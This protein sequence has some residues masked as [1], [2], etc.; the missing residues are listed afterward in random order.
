E[1]N[2]TYTNGFPGTLNN[3]YN[4]AA[5]CVSGCA[6]GSIQVYKANL[7]VTISQIASAEMHFRLSQFANIPS[8]S[9]VDNERSTLNPNDFSNPKAFF[10]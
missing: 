4:V 1:N 7:W 3:T 10:E 8:T 2:G 6:Q 5:V 9:Q